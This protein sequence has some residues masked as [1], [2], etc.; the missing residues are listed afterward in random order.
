VASTLVQFLPVSSLRRTVWTNYSQGSVASFATQFNID[1]AGSLPVGGAAVA[2]ASKAGAAT[3]AEI[4]VAPGTSFE[5]NPGDWVSCVNGVWQTLPASAMG[6]AVADGA[7]NSNQT[8]TSATAAFNN[9]LDVGATIAGPGIP[10]GTTV[11]A[12]GSSTS[13]TISLAA[14]ATATNQPLIITRTTSLYT[15]VVC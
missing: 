12:V 5:M 1:W 6:R 11:T 8:V 10:S 13:V 4:V 15:P 3:V 14:T 9:P 7:T 2:I